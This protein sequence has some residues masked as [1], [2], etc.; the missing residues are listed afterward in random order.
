MI[1]QLYCN[2][3][4]K[5]SKKLGHLEEEKLKKHGVLQQ[6]Y[7]G[8]QKQKKH[9]KFSS[10]QVIKYQN[11]ER[12]LIAV[13]KFPLCTYLISPILSTYAKS[14]QKVTK[15]NQSKFYSTY[16]KISRVSNSFCFRSN[17]C[18]LNRQKSTSLNSLP[19]I[20]VEEYDENGELKNFREISTDCKRN[21]AN[22]LKVA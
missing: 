10:I 12:Y 2:Q 14:Y 3:Y 21:F 6:N 18:S 20:V 15:W 22:K 5:L 11:E 4:R 17:P 16:L 9:S 1:L 7:K 13:F 8:V 19:K